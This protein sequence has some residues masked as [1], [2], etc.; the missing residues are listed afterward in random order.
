MAD[1]NGVPHA[2][3]GVRV[4]SEGV[5]RERLGQGEEAAELVVRREDARFEFVRPEA[6]ARLE[7]E[8]VLDE[9]LDRPDLAGTRGR[10]GIPEEEIAGERHG[11]AHLAAQ[12][13]VDRQVEHSAHRV[14]AGELEGR[15]DL[16]SVVVQSRGGI[17]DLEPQGCRVEDVV[18]E[19]LGPQRLD[20][21]LR[22]LAS[23]AHLAEPDDAALGLELDDGA[24][25]AAP[26]GARGVAQRRFQRHADGRR[27][28]V[29]YPRSPRRPAGQAS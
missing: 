9:L 29:G 18:A 12:E 15:V 19:Q 2:V 7:V 25:E 11:V 27:P 8:S 16:R 4:D 1:A 28:Q 22:A 14:E 6:E 13:V 26:V 20:G 17:E 10:V 3:R 23:A 21:Q 5:V 24:H